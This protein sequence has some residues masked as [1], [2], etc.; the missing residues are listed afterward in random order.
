MHFRLK[1]LNIWIRRIIFL[2]LLFFS[3]TASLSIWLNEFLRQ[4]LSTLIFHQTDELYTVTFSDIDVNPFTLK[5]SVENLNIKANPQGARHYQQKA[6]VNG[7]ID[8]VSLFGI[9]LYEM[10]VNEILYIYQVKIDKPQINIE[11][12][13]FFVASFQPPKKKI[14]I[15]FHSVLITA[16]EFNFRNTDSLYVNLLIDRV[17]Y[18]DTEKSFILENTSG[19][20]SR[21]DLT[22]IDAKVKSIHLSG[23]TVDELMT[24]KSLSFLSLK[25]D[26]LIAKIEQGKN[27][28]ID[29]NKIKDRKPIDV[30]NFDPILEQL[31]GANFTMHDNELFYHN[32]FHTTHIIGKNISIQDSLI[33]LY[34]WKATVY[35]SIGKNYQSSTRFEY[36]SANYANY[37]KTDQVRSALFR[38]IVIDQPVHIS[39]LDQ[40][41]EKNR[42]T[43]INSN[44]TS[45]SENFFPDLHFIFDTVLV[46]N[47]HLRMTFNKNKLRL[48]GVSLIITN[49]AKSLSEMLFP[50]EQSLAANIIDARYSF[51]NKVIK[52][53]NFRFDN[54]TRKIKI[55]TFALYDKKVHT[56]NTIN[57]LKLQF[58]DIHMLLFPIKS[59]FSND[60]LLTIDSLIIGSGK[61]SLEKRYQPKKIPLNL[62]LKPGVKINFISVKEVN[63][64]FTRKM[65]FEKEKNGRF[66]FTSIKLIGENISN[67]TEKINE[68]NNILNFS[69]TLRNSLVNAK[70]LCNFADPEFNHVLFA[71]AYNL[72]LAAYN[73]EFASVAGIQVDEGLINSVEIEIRGNA[74][75]VKSKI[76]IKYSNLN[77]KVLRNKDQFKTLSEGEEVHYKKFLTNILNKTI[78]DSNL[79]DEKNNAI[80]LTVKTDPEKFVVNT[81]VRT[82]LISTV[83]T[84]VP[85]SHK[86][87]DFK[88][89]REEKKQKRKEKRKERQKLVD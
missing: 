71:S 70:L 46:K 9:G 47:G 5:A 8:E 30:S 10:F 57:P 77:L 28:R 31:R 25:T 35:D 1:N 65:D 33:Q 79:D 74:D 85:A 42:T 54:P 19:S 50:F 29:T 45:T 18:Y 82:I 86:L 75:E 6:F 13:P 26:G 36:L 4:Q 53:N 15:N 24:S 61:I 7:T 3:I 58:S 14:K 21:T 69:F 16:G 48:N 20:L 80:V 76:K 12:N 22:K 39:Y 27:S 78:K 88:K 60:K 2:L 17:S 84:I 38:K 51:K 72:K 62:Y 23:A 56:G 34:N 68:K 63:F 11:E 73:E 43:F 67:R 83:E 81:W 59:G 87:F 41:D 40:A 55:D 52:I 32:K 89:R 66:I 44:D 37:L 64:D 49:Q